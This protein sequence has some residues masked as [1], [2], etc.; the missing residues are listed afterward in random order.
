M[1]IYEEILICPPVGYRRPQIE[2]VVV[3]P[4]IMILN[5][6]REEEGFVS[7]IQ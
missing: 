5:G 7:R 2:L 6:G 4:S 1:R 3:V